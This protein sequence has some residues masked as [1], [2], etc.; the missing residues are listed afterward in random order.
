M[1]K[2]FFLLLF[3]NLFF[4]E[5]HFLKIY[6]TASTD[7]KNNATSAVVL[8]VDGNLLGSCDHKILKTNYDWARKVLNDFPEL[9]AFYTIQCF[10]ILP[11]FFEYKM[12]SV[13]KDTRQSEGL[14]IFQRVDTCFLDEEHGE[15]PSMRYGYNGEDFLELNLDSLSWTVLSPKAEKTKHFWD[16]DIANMHFYKEL[17]THRCPLWLKTFLDYGKSL[18]KTTDPPSVSLLQKSPSSPIR[19]HATG[20]YPNRALLFWRKDGDETHEDVEH[21]EILPNEDGSFQMTVDLNVSSVNIEDW[22]RFDCVFQFSGAVDKIILKLDKAVIISNSGRSHQTS[23]PIIAAVVVF[24][25]VAIVAG[26]FIAFKIKRK[27]HLR[28]V[29]FPSNTSLTY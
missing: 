1:I 13:R 7:F 6:F 10:Q 22:E 12:S 9:H 24:G 3:C 18:L 26:V 17:L 27:T 19:C 20:F 28:I 21:G 15:V 5:K 16:E 23:A 11:S 14:H 25:A 2:L 4:A 8:D 29:E